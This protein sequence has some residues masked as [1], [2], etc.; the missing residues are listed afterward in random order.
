MKNLVSTIPVRWIAAVRIAGSCGPFVFGQNAEIRNW[1]T[2]VFWSPSQAGLDPDPEKPADQRS[3]VLTG[4]LPLV[5]VTPCRLVDTR[6]AYSSLGFAGAFGA[7]QMLAGTERSIPVPS[8]GC[9]IPGGARAYSFNITVVPSGPLGYLA[10]WPSGQ[11]MPNVST[12]NSPNG[13]IV[14]NAA[15]VPAGTGGAVSVFV[16]NNA[17]VII[18]VNGYF[19]DSSGAIGSTGATGPTGPAGPTGA[20]SVIA[21]PQGPTGTTGVTGPAGATGVTGNTGPTGAVGMAGATGATGPTGGTG[22]AGT[23][24]NQFSV[25]IAPNTITR[26]IALS[27]NGANSG[28]MSNPPVPGAWNLIPTACSIGD[29]DVVFYSTLATSITL[30]TSTDPSATLLGS[31]QTA[32]T[33]TVSSAPGFGTCTGGSLSIPA[34]TFA[35]WQWGGN[36]DGPGG[37]ASYVYIATKCQ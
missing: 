13:G 26:W 8:G 23:A 24:G 7:P 37:L 2:P 25:S 20:N 35:T 29:A 5:A 16:T 34:H 27:G 3:A 30:I 4:P 22:A 36:F 17:D 15:I 19:T 32:Y 1:Q 9:G 21:G 18:D 11:P 33:C 14:A 28:S 10:I 12:L 6:L 31:N